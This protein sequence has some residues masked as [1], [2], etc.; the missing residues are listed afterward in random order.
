MR[1]GLEGRCGQK[2]PH[3]CVPRVISCSDKIEGPVAFAFARAGS[4]CIVL[5]S[6]Q[7]HDLMLLELKHINFSTTLDVLNVLL[8]RVAGL[9]FVLTLWQL[10]PQPYAV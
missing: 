4:C 6:L 9:E 3:I 7:P 1:D 8:S 5:R 10:L 2:H